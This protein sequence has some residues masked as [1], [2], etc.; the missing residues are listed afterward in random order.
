MKLKDSWE[1]PEGRFPA[2]IILD[3]EAGRVLDEQ[4]GQSKSTIRKPGIKKNNHSGDERT[5]NTAGIYGAGS[6]IIGGGHT[7]KGGASRFFYCPKVSKKERNMGLDDFEEKPSHHNSGG[8]G[9]KC[10]VEKR[11]EENQTNT[12]TMKNIHP[13]VKP[14]SLMRYLTKL[15]TPPGGICLD[16]FMGSGS[17]GI[18]ARLEG[19]NFIGMEMD[20][21]Y[22]K[23]AEARINSFEEYKK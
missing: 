20:E 16:P 15:I 7:D 2:N 23:I 11:L 18:A 3:E 9:R 13:T 19:F 12:P 21:E 10:S 6:K 14:V 1:Q 4:S 5:P 17:T 22:I 8:I